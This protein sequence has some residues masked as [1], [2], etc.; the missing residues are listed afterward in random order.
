M[1]RLK[2]LLPAIVSFLLVYAITSAP[3]RTVQE[4]V[5]SA[6]AYWRG[7]QAVIT[8]TT[9]AELRSQT[10]L[11]RLTGKLIPS[12]PQT[13]VSKAHVYTW[14]NQRW[15]HVELATMQAPRNFEL[16][17]YAGSFYVIDLRG[18]REWNGHALVA[19]SRQR[20]IE[21]PDCFPEN[22]DNYMAAGPEGSKQLF[23]VM[24][25]PITRDEWHPPSHRA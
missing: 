8:L 22:P 1:S 15:E 4:S 13:R 5:A 20:A 16:W 18:V 17:P 14:K 3:R 23:A 21:L 12:R 19:T 2:I 11:D 24:Q 7:D 6:Q 10:L 25:D 9:Q